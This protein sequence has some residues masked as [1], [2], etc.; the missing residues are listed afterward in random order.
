MILGVVAIYEFALGSLQF[1]SIDESVFITGSKPGME[2]ALV[3]QK[4]HARWQSALCGYTF[5]ALYPL[6]LL[7]PVDFLRLTS[8]IFAG[9]WSFFKDST[10][11]H[12]FKVLAWLFMIPTIPSCFFSI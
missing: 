8:F 1:H 12:K 10:S 7:V 9:I 4:G 5:E 3:V 2:N 6:S 11:S